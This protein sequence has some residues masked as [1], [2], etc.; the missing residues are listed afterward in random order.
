MQ[1]TPV[2][3]NQNQYPNNNISFGL[4]ATH[5]AKKA[6]K[7]FAKQAKDFYDWDEYVQIAKDVEEISEHLADRSTD[8]ILLGTT[9]KYGNFT[10]AKADMPEYPLETRAHAYYRMVCSTDLLKRLKDPRALRQE[11][12][13]N[14]TKLKNEEADRA[15]KAK[16]DADKIAKYKTTMKQKA[17]EINRNLNSTGFIGFIRRM[18]GYS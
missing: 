11:L 13:E 6:L 3:F 15:R 7:L 2:N 18:F 10:L 5:G 9:D 17:A 12:A 1:I 16:N 4:Q 8:D 14:I